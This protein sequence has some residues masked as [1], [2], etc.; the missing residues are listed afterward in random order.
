MNPGRSGQTIAVVGAGGQLGQDLVRLL[1][2]DC[3]PLT[4]AD[5]DLDRPDSIRAGLEA[6][7][8]ALVI[9][10]AAYNFVDR[11]EDE[12]EQAL[13]TNAVGP[14]YLARFCRELNA[15]LVHISTDYVFGRDRHRQQPYR[16]TDRPG[17]VN[18][19][20][21]SKLTGEYFVQESWPEGTYV[22]RTCG[23]YGLHGRGGKGGNFVETILRLA[24][25]RPELRVVDDQRCTPTFTQD[26]AQA[27]L[28]LIR[29]RPEP[30]IYHVTN[31]GDCTWYEF[32]AAILRESGLDARCVPI[33]SA[34]YSTRAERPRYSV[35][36]NTKWRSLGLPELRHWR[37]ALK[38]YLAQRSRFR[39][40]AS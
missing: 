19:Y 16:E 27:I 20:G 34:E 38:D 28:D 26:L 32:A 37:E 4:R 11:A 2:E 8:P 3:R 21:I 33:S 7:R 18:C 35:L 5:L 31:S 22:V 17:P 40:S 1:G 39:R 15:P 10:T 30:G 9:N 36:D 24:A 29:L 6:V 25:E 23:L 13:R 12:P 14:L